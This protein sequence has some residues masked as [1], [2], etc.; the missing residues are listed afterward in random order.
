MV[1][2]LCFISL[3]HREKVVFAGEPLKGVGNII[4]QKEEKA[5][6][7]NNAKN[8]Q[9]WDGI[10]FHLL[11]PDTGYDAVLSQVGLGKVSKCTSYLTISTLVVQIKLYL[12]W[13]EEDRLHHCSLF[14]L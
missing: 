5:W 8:V 1:I 4:L 12:P 10:F 11:Q 2:R 14:A 9:R 6:F 3:S 13:R 7:S